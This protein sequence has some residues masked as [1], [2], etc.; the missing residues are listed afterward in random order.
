MLIMILL[1]IDPIF[2]DNLE[3]NEQEIEIM[4]KHR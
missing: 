2:V 3:S 4:L 1:S